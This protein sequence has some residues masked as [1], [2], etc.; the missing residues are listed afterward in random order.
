VELDGLY[1]QHSVNIEALTSN[2]ES[3]LAQL[4]AISLLESPSVGESDA[5]RLDVVM[6]I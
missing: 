1:C 3:I 4:P 2:M 5:K 6:V